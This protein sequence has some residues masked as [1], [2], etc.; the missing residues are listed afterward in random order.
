METLPVKKW[1]NSNGIRLSKHIMN[2]LGMETDDEI[3]IETEVINGRKRVIL[4]QVIPSEFTIEELFKDFHS[5]PF[6]T[7][8][9]DLGEAVGNEKW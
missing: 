8:L 7:E 3:I 2:F 5:E 1:G 4:E 9:Q 6:H